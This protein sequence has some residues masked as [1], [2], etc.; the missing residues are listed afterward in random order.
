MQRANNLLHAL[1][2]AMT[3]AGKT[4]ISQKRLAELLGMAEP[5]MSRWMSGKSKLGQIELLL[6]FI[7]K[8]PEDR[9]KKEI[10]EVLAQ[11]EGTHYVLRS[12]KR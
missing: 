6:R 9:W 12:K 5:T 8:V 11:S 10:A 3:S 4:S 7:E 2:G 1:R